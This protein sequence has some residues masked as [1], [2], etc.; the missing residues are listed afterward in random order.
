MGRIRFTVEQRYADLDTMGHVNNV[1]YLTY[2]QEVRLKLLVRLLGD[3]LFRMNHVVV[4]NEIDY[5]SSLGL[6]PEGVVIDAWVERI[7]SSSYTVAYDVHAPSG[8]VAARAKTVLVHLDES[9]A[10]SP[11]PQEQRDMLAVAL[12]GSSS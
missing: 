1:A 5:L 11:L 10:A 4:R 8:E 9:G 6:S 3:R 7:G 2:L 12:E